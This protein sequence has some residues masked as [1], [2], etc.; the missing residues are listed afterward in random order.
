MFIAWQKLVQVSTVFMFKFLG[1]DLHMLKPESKESQYK[2]KNLPDW[3]LHK[4]SVFKANIQ[5]CSC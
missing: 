4:V 3:I 1:C 5:A 2:L